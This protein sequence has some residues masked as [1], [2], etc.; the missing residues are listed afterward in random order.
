MSALA[1]KRTF[2]RRLAHVRLTPKT[3]LSGNAAS[4]GPELRRS[5]DRCFRM[6]QVKRIISRFLIIGLFFSS[7]VT[8]YAQA[9][10]PNT[11][12]LKADA[13]KVVSIIREDKA[14]TQA[15]CQINSLGG[16]IDQAAQARDEQKVDVL[17]KRINDLEKQLGPEY[18]ALFDALDNA[19]QNSKDF[20][21]ILSMF[22]KLSESCP[23]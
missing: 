17:T 16:E 8:L 23:H 22:D 11:A 19:D 14:K 21:D 12:K 15:Y 10:Q 1:H 9:Q 13:Q 20:Q 5:R 3:V 2:P 18:P 7:A 6:V 4:K